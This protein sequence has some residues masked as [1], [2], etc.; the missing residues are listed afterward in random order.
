[1]Y[2]KLVYKHTNAYSYDHFKA[3]YTPPTDS[4][5]QRV[6][7]CPVFDDEANKFKNLR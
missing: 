4:V 3:D 7:A 1:M 5:V 6:W 2:L